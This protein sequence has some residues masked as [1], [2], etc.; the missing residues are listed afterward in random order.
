VTDWDEVL[1]HDFLVPPGRQ[2]A[3]LA[4]EL[5]TMLESPDP[6]VRDDTAYLVLAIWT[7]RG[8][9][10][11]ELTGI[12]DRLVARLADGPIYQRTFAAIILS[13]VVLRD[14]TT[15]ELDDGH[16][17]GWL[18]ALSTWWRQETDLR[19][20]DPQLGWLHAA[21]HGADALRAFGRSPRLAE[22]Q[23]QDLLDLAA[24]RLLADSGYLFAHGEDDRI[25]YALASVL[26]R[27]ELPASAAASWLSRLHEAIAGGTPGPVPPWA[28]NT[29]RTLASLYIF[30]DRGVAWYDPQTDAFAPPV[31]L[32]H[33]AELKD[34]IAAVLRLPWRGLG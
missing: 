15:S 10:D 12:G 9:L 16:V 31:Q 4:G 3:E 21:A 33:A 19:G 34:Q 5:L 17:L 7:G 18:D 32:P 25:A 14:A 11:G 24:D 23:L 30:A 6:K 20:W 8:V 1:G 28:A 27:A 26:T 22:Q 29:L 13:W 2:A